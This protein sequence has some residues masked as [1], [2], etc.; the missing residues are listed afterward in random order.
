MSGGRSRSEAHGRQQRC[1]CPCAL[2]DA[3]RSRRSV[4]RAARGAGA[5]HRPRPVRVAAGSTARAGS[6][7][8]ARRHAVR[9]EPRPSA[10]VSATQRRDRR[11]VRSVERRATHSPR[12]R[13]RQ[14]R[15]MPRCRSA[16]GERRGRHRRVRRRD[17][18]DHVRAPPGAQRRTGEPSPSGPVGGRR[19][20]DR[21]PQCGRRGDGRPGAPSAPGGRRA[22]GA[23]D[24]TVDRLD[25]DREPARGRCPPAG[26]GRRWSSPSTC[27]PVALHQ[28]LGQTRRTRVCAPPTDGA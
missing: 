13:M 24:H 26:A 25:A 17:P 4:A 2:R 1:R 18:D 14:W 20:D 7:R 11:R 22:V 6:P 3:R 28:A 27:V 12:C 8:S 16:R 9:A 15:R 21:P 19:R 10:S 5:P 23:T